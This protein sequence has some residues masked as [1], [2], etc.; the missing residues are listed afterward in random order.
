MTLCRSRNGLV[1][2]NDNLRESSAETNAETKGGDPS[3]QLHSQTLKAKRRPTSLF[4]PM[5]VLLNLAIW[6]AGMD[7]MGAWIEVS[8]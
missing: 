8:R 7:A 2:E 6:V 5:L 3:I 4:L 1:C